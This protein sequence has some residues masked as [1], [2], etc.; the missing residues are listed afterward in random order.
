MKYHLIS[1]TRVTTIKN[2]GLKEIT[3]TTYLDFD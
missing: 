2:R 1:T 3:K